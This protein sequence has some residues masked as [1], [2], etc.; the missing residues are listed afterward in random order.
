[1]EL[2]WQIFRTI[3]TIILC[4]V[5]V[6]Q[7]TSRAIQGAASM[8]ERHEQWMASYGRQYEGVAEKEKRYRIFKSNVEFI[9][10]VNGAGNRP[11]RLGINGF[12]DLTNDEFRAAYIGGAF[13]P[14]AAAKSSEMNTFRYDD[15]ISGAIPPS[16]DWRKKGAVTPIR[17]G[18]C[19]AWTFPAVDTVEAITKIKTGKLYTLSVQEI[20]DC[21][22]GCSDGCTGGFTIEAFEFIKNHGLTTQSNYP[23]TGTNGTC[24]AKKEAQPVAKISGYETVPAGDENALMKAVAKQPVAVY[25]DASGPEFQFYAGG[26][27][28]GDCGTT[29]DLGGTVVGYGV[30]HGDKQEYWVLKNSWGTRW[31]EKGYMRLA[32]GINKEGG[33]CGVAMEATYPVV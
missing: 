22:N 24:N 7:A 30:S 8:A 16:I 3:L 29:L 27:F 18:E 6:S 11:Y 12:A 21:I 4:S 31:G 19:G 9:D 2:K 1:M 15:D 23:S 32:R 13:K 25:V 5:W 33:Q 14:S 10:M 26:V 20:V 28:S 17:G